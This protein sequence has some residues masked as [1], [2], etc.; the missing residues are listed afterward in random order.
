MPSLAQLRAAGEI[1]ALDEH[2]ARTLESLV[3][4]AGAEVV[5]AAALAS[6]HVGSGHVC[7]DLKRL[8]EGPAPLRA[9]PEHESIG[10]TALEWP[11][12]QA[13]LGAL[14]ASEL[15]ESVDVHDSLGELA[16]EVTPLV[17]DAAGRLYL[18]RYWE[19]Q[20]VLA[21][22]LRRRADAGVDVPVLD[23]DVL[24]RG[25]DRLFP[26]LPK[27][28][29][30]PQRVAAERS[31]RRRF[32]VISGGPGTGKTSTVVKILVL[33]VEQALAKGAAMPR[34]A[35]VAP[36]GKAAAILADSI[37]ES[38]AQIDCDDRVREAIPQ[39]ASTIH[40]CLGTRGGSSTRFLH[41]E[42]NPLATD[43]L[44]VDEASMVDLALMA[45]L[46][47]AVPDPARL[48]LLGDRDQLASVEAGAVLG[49]ICNV[50]SENDTADGGPMA[51][52]LVQ[53]TRSYRYAADSG[54]GA[55]ARAI[56]AGDAE[57]AIALLEDAR[58]GDVSLHP[59]DAAGLGPVLRDEVTRG[60]DAFLKAEAPGERLRAMQA[61]RVLCA[62]RRGP[63]GV[64]AINLE[65][66]AVLAS[67]GK[68][69]PTAG[70]YPGRP[71]MLTRNDHPLALYNGDVGLI[72]WRGGEVAGGPRALF[73][74]DDG[75]ER[76]LSPLRLVSAETVFAMSIHKSQGSEF[77]AV[78]VVLPDHVSP[79][80]SREL[81][82]TAV[83]RAR[84]RVSIHASPPV[85][86]EAIHRRVERASGLREALWS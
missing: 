36:T 19:H 64:D 18:R 79:V 31:L 66:E 30:D 5:L 34:V 68:L 39:H 17:L 45:R 83:S 85:L 35:L 51:G 76:W 1:S 67:T 21:S 56:N 25:L 47:T 53:L 57:A 43:L 74:G 38:L 11:Q 16:G 2:F 63:G 75:E 61:Y 42:R 14:R 4:E 86:V 26:R 69:A 23:E 52:S 71:I 70:H 77:E 27:S 48:I 13:W 73:F 15:V 46:C 65:I 3:D 22:S 55:L 59:L 28:D 84:T 32:C 20:Q 41:D 81:L 37:R 24:A 6:R 9:E 80:V 60:Y 72:A 78:S 29:V 50:G 10:L 49:D 12:R 7:L 62:H 58:E 44:L 82:Y 54:I 33:I 40:R 8:S